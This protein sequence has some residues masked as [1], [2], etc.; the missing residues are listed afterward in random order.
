MTDAFWNDLKSLDGLIAVVI[1]VISIALAFRSERRSE[2]LSRELVQLAAKYEASQARLEAQ[3]TEVLSQLSPYRERLTELM[4]VIAKGQIPADSSMTTLDRV[5]SMAEEISQRATGIFDYSFLGQLARAED[6]PISGSY[7]NVQ[8]ALATL[9]MLL[10][11]AVE[12]W[13]S[14]STKEYLDDAL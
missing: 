8:F 2:R 14:D 11:S 13:R 7:G 6:K 10:T 3:R 12:H 9:S 1:S 5:R 4:N